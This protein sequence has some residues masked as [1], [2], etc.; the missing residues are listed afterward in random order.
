[1][2]FARGIWCFADISSVSPSLVQTLDQQGFFF[3]FFRQ[4]VLGLIYMSFFSVYLQEKN[5]I[6]KYF[7]F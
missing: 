2:F 3:F 5:N 6:N 1:M 7:L 4:I